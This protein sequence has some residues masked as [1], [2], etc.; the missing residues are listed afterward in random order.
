MAGNDVHWLRDLLT[1]N[2][3][4]ARILSSGY[5]ANTHTGSW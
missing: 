3:P 4:H 5:D 2:I 1:Y